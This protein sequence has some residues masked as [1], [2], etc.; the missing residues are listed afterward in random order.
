MNLASIFKTFKEKFIA[1]ELFPTDYPIPV[2]LAIVFSNG[3]IFANSSASNT[4]YFRNLL[5]LGLEYDKTNIDFASLEENFINDAPRLGF[6]DVEKREEDEKIIFVLGDKSIMSVSY[7]DLKT[8][9]DVVQYFSKCISESLENLQKHRYI[10]VKKEIKSI[11]FYWTDATLTCIYL[12][13]EPSSNNTLT[14]DSDI[15]LRYLLSL[16]VT[17]WNDNLIELSENAMDEGD[18][19]FDYNEI[20]ED[21]INEIGR[22]VVDNLAKNPLFHTD[23]EM[24]IYQHDI[25]DDSYDED[26]DDFFDED[27]D[28]FFDEDDD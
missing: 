19:S 16:D 11:K 27:D 3:K 4:D 20:F 7:D 18:D 24:Q 25:D 22:Q 6:Q 13:Y 1:Q 26:D 9:E 21:A 2:T 28:I 12:N 15:V 10:V 17:A 5:D 14:N 23:I 8:T